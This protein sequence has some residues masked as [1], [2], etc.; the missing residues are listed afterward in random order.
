MIWFR[1]STDQFSPSQM[2]SGRVVRSANDGV[3]HETAG[4]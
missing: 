3:S 1:M 4:R 2:L